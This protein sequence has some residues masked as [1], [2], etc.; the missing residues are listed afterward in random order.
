[1][2]SVCVVVCVRERESRQGRWEVGGRRGGEGEREGKG[3]K[4]VEGVKT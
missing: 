1:M 4:W 2:Y 3:V